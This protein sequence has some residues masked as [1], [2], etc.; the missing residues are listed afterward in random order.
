MEFAGPA[1][2]TPTATRL[3]R[4]TSFLPRNRTN[5]F[6]PHHIAVQQR[7]VLFRCPYRAG[8]RLDCMPRHMGRCDFL[9]SSVLQLGAE[10]AQLMLPLTLDH[11]RGVSSRAR[12]CG[13]VSAL[14]S[15]WY[16]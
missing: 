13:S 11:R 6:V 8:H 10:S 2:I 12:V 1:C 7:I 16:R 4:E 15:Q 5:L 3:P 9:L 14:A